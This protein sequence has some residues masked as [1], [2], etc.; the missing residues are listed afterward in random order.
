MSYTIMRCEV[1]N[2]VIDPDDPDY[3]EGK[4]HNELCGLCQDAYKEGL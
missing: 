3:K 2:D 1:C 4:D